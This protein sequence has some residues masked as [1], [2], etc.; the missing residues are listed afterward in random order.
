MPNDFIVCNVIFR[1]CEM[2]IYSKT[3]EIFS[4]ALQWL[5]IHLLTRRCCYWR[6]NIISSLARSFERRTGEMVLPRLLHRNFRYTACGERVSERERESRQPLKIMVFWNT[7]FYGLSEN[8][9]KIIEISLVYQAHT[10]HGIQP[11]YS[12]QMIQLMSS[13]KISGVIWQTKM[14]KFSAF[15]EALPNVSRS[16]YTVH[17][18]LCIAYTAHSIHTHNVCV[19]ICANLFIFHVWLL[20]DAYTRSI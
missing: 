7:Y 20:C 14:I 6:N 1:I 3:R 4:M 16:Y 17:S 5:K 8:S 10:R 18:G 2:F 11:S 15:I 13:T 12:V 19:N 9:Y